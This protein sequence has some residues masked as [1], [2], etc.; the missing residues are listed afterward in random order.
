MLE[1]E[2]KGISMADLEDSGELETLDAKLASALFPIFPVP[3]QK[4]IEVLE[5][6]AHTRAQVVT[7][8]Q[9]VLLMFQS[10]YINETDMY[11]VDIEDLRNGT[12]IGQDIEGYVHKYD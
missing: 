8:R 7:G 10:L 1:I 9:H 2:T 12:M 4:E 3:L 5:E 6:K 11:F